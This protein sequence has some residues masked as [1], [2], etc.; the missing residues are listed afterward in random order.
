MPLA[1]AAVAQA[2]HDEESFERASWRGTR[3]WQCR[4]D[5]M[6]VHR[7]ISSSILAFIFRRPARRVSLLRASSSLA[8]SASILGLVLFNAHC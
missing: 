7:C 6:L 3:R 1:L 8:S 5:E 4:L 2:V